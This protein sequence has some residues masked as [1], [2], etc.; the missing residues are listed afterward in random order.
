[1]I[2]V[3]CSVSH[4]QPAEAAKAGDIHVGCNMAIEVSVF[5]LSVFC[6]V[7]L[8]YSLCFLAATLEGH[9]QGWSL[10]L[11]GMCAVPEGHLLPQSL[12][13]DWLIWPLHGLWMWHDISKVQTGLMHK[14]MVAFMNTAGR[15][16][17]EANKVGNGFYLNLNFRNIEGDDHKVK[18]KKCSNDML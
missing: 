18:L 7:S 1:M 14:R 8:G 2:F 13:L 11:C 10:D 9:V 5:A 6:H 15:T 12:R 17:S 4:R 3:P 16:G